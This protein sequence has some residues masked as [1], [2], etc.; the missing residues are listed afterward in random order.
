[1]V[2]PAA[3]KN[4]NEAIV[5]AAKAFERLPLTQRTKAN[6]LKLFNLFN[7]NNTNNS[8]N[9][10]NNADQI[11][12]YFKDVMGLSVMKTSISQEEFLENIDDWVSEFAKYKVPPKTAEPPYKKVDAK[13]AQELAKNLVYELAPLGATSSVGSWFADL[14][15]DDDGR[16]D[17]SLALFG[18]GEDKINESNIVEVLNYI[19]PSV[20]NRA[21]KTLDSDKE[22]EIRGLIGQ[23]L[24][25]RINTLKKAKSITNEEYKAATELITNIEANE[26]FDVSMIRVRKLLYNKGVKE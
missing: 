21:I 15:G 1:M 2:E 12:D 10:L 19:T 3:Q 7:T 4:N 23:A 14:V 17:D 16:Y 5:K 13:K 26:K 11:D 18:E 8:K 6:A 9:K 22:P 25:D 24:T 20:L